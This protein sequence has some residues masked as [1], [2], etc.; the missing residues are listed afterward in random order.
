[1]PNTFILSHKEPYVAYVGVCCSYDLA[2]V[3]GG[4]VESKVCRMSG[5]YL[6]LAN[7]C[8]AKVGAEM[9]ITCL[10]LF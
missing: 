7:R 4:G 6:R 1:M 9:E 3:N 5:G 10:L 8:R 2:P